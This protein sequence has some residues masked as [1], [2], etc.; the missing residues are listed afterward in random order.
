MFYT[1]VFSCYLEKLLQVFMGMTEKAR[2]A[3]A[4][5]SW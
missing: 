3:A 2:Q 5:L 4:F 1:H